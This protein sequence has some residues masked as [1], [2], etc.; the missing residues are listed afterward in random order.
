M[1]LYKRGMCPLPSN[2]L[3]KPLS[4]LTPVLAN[5]CVTITPE[6]VER[7]RLAIEGVHRLTMRKVNGDLKIL[8]TNIWKILTDNLEIIYKYVKF[9]LQ[10]L[11]GEWKILFFKVAQDN[12]EIG[13]NDKNIFQK[14]IH[15]AFIERCST[16]LV[17]HQ[18]TRFRRH[19]RI[20]GSKSSFGLSEAHLFCFRVKFT[21]ASLSSVDFNFPGFHLKFDFTMLTT[22]VDRICGRV[23]VVYD[24]VIF[25]E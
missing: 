11:T 8:K 25:V 7:M 5:L 15:S 18:I 10:F 2:L 16:F 21:R 1:C 23:E 6:N 12:L 19:P 13:V 3:F 20:E 22:A 14:I 17:K 24:G 9:I 4:T